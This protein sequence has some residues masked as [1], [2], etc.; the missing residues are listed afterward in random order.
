ME[1]LKNIKPN[2]RDAYEFRASNGTFTN[3]FQQEW[4]EGN[5][6]KG[7]A[8]LQPQQK[9]H[10]QVLIATTPETLRATSGREAIN[11]EFLKSFGE[12][13]TFSFSYFYIVL[14]HLVLSALD[15]KLFK[16]H[17][18]IVGEHSP[19]YPS[20]TIVYTMYCVFV[21]SEHKSAWNEEIVMVQ[22]IKDHSDRLVEQMAIPANLALHLHQKNFFAIARYLFTLS[23][24]VIFKAK[25]QLVKLLHAS[26]HVRAGPRM[27]SAGD[28]RSPAEMRQK[29]KR[30]NKI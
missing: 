2:N 24:L 16:V 8:A 9:N 13:T 3:L 27:H 18:R 17:P 21:L 10:F 19:C 12:G 5:Y 14:P 26:A 25:K 11:S 4:V 1:C 30:V 15:L 6:L 7:A 20:Y 22:H 29:K 23:Q 28:V